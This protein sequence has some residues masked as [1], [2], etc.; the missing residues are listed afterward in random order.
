M[1]IENSNEAPKRKKK[2]GPE[3]SS[4]PLTPANVRMTKMRVRRK[5][6]EEE[7]QKVFEADWTLEQ[8][9]QDLLEGGGSEEEVDSQ[10]R[11]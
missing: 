5:L 8:E 10:V 2:P 4:L 6:E 7:Q 11:E 3:L 1:I 9:A